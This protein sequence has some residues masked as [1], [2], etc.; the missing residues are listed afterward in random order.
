MLKQEGSPEYTFG[1]KNIQKSELRSLHKFEQDLDL[2]GETYM[3]FSS[4]FSLYRLMLDNPP[5]NT[6]W[7]GKVMLVY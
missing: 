5:L 3:C 7:K 2:L 4:P 1:V 6:V